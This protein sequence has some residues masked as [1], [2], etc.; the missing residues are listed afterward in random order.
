MIHPDMDLLQSFVEG[1]K[2]FESKYED[3]VFKMCWDIIIGEYA[4]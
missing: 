3:E 4:G 1:K 2:M